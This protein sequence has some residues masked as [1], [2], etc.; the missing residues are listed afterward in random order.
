MKNKKQLL[1]AHRKRKRKSIARSKL[2]VGHGAPV[3][4]RT[5]FANTYCVGAKNDVADLPPKHYDS[6]SVKL[7]LKRQYDIS[8]S[9][10]NDIT[11]SKVLETEVN[12]ENESKEDMKSNDHD[13]QN[14]TIS[15]VKANSSEKKQ[16]I[17]IVVSDRNQKCNLTRMGKSLA[18]YDK[19]GQLDDAKTV[20]ADGTHRALSVCFCVMYNVYVGCCT[21]DQIHD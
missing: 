1:T 4:C 3:I 14:N 8:G 2:G 21:C 12:D 17:N 5:P 19:S 6:H 13:I 20:A 7:T 15:D 10:I 18:Y 11:V 9:E 16:F